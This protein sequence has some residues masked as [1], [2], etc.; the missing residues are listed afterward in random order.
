MWFKYPGNILCKWLI[1]A[2]LTTQ[3]ILYYKSA[4]THTHTHFGGSPRRMLPA[5]QHNLR[6]T[7]TWFGSKLGFRI[8]LKDYFTCWAGDGTTIWLLDEHSITWA[9]AA[10]YSY[11]SEREREQMRIYISYFMSLNWRNGVCFSF[12]NMLLKVLMGACTC[13]F[14]LLLYVHVGVCVFV[15]KCNW[16]SLLLNKSIKDLH[17]VWCHSWLGEF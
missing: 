12:R 2:S 14:E 17:F 6:H 13:L 15:H 5:Y 10:S 16:Y 7:R 8:S 11:H 9:T 4:F 3:C 1:P